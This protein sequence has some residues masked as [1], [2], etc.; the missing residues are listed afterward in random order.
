VPLLHETTRP[1][2]TYRIA[3]GLR[4]DETDWKHTLNM[5][6]HRRQAEITQILLDSR[7]PLLDDDGRLIAAKAEVPPEPDGYRRE[8]YRA[9]TPA[10]LKGATVL[11]NH[12]A[13]AL[14]RQHRAA[15]IDV[16]PQP[17]RPAELAPGTLWRDTPHPT[18]P[19][20]IWLANTGFGDLAPETEAYFAREL[21]AATGGDRAHPLVIFCQ[22]AC[23][24][25]WN[26]ARRALEA[27]YTAVSWY[28]DG[29]DGWAEAGLPLERAEPAP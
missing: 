9:P 22:R 24:M 5:A 26:A 15:F 2:L 18:I 6:L 10:T 23:W 4:P 29:T 7:V 21:A 16:M 12:A 17:K 14:W 3:L 25:S 19:G 1:P 28:P 11:D 13:E 20:A 8:G 27:G